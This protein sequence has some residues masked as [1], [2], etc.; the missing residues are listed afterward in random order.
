MRCASIF[1]DPTN[2]FTLP[3]V[4][5]V[6]SGGKH[7][8]AI[9]HAGSV[10]CWGDNESAQCAA[11]LEACVAERAGPDIISHCRVPPQR[12]ALPEPAIDVTAGPTHSCAALR[13]GRVFCWGNDRDAALG[14][15]SST[16]CP[17]WEKGVCAL[18]PQA[19]PGIYDATRVRA[20]KR[21][22]RTWAL[23]SD[24]S[25]LVWPTEERRKQK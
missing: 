5:R 6:V 10:I 13:D 11:P 14:F 9:T 18:E 3:D 1:Y 21:D 7:F 12:V 8:C 4:K 20:L 2:T 17:V 23:L 19:V 24:G 15:A 22:V 16:R 25:A